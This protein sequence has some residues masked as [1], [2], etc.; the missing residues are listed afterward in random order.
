MDLSILGQGAVEGLEEFLAKQLFQ[1]ELAAK[2]QEQARRARLEEERFS[3]E[4][5]RFR[6]QQ[7]GEDEDRR[8][9][10]EQFTTQQERL[11]RA[12]R[13]DDNALGV[14]RMIGDFLIQRPQP[15][16]AERGTIG[17]MAYAEGMDAPKMGLTPEEVQA[18]SD[19]EMQEF[20]QKEETR[21]RIG[22]K[23]REPSAASRDQDW[24]IR[25]GQPVP[26]PKG[27]AQPGDRPY[28]AVA[29]R[30]GEAAN[31]PSEFTINQ[32]QM[33]VEKVSDLLPRIGTMTAGPVGSVLARVPGTDAANVRADVQSLAANIAFDQLQ[34]MREAS[35]TGGAL[36]QVSD[37][38]AELLANVVASLRQD[39]SPSNLRRNLLTVQQ[40]AQRFLDAAGVAPQPNAFR[41]P[42]MGRTGA[43][44]PPSRPGGRFTIVG[45]K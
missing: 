30:Q 1:Q 28:D 45:V 13:A 27:T 20:E 19:A 32:S 21:A 39:Q 16:A 44:T 17:A 6:D 33:V 43:P 38:E 34:R 11:G 41:E 25:N 42:R 2:Q 35:K 31:Q 3:F 22:A 40:S 8:F 18:A 23:Y 12:E 36:G 26:I 9:R 5:Q 7:A 15:G 29:A 14:R 10:R 4:Q 37:R 24:V